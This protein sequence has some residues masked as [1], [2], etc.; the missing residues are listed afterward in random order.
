MKQSKTKQRISR[1]ERQL[2]VLQIQEYIDQ[3][4]PEMKD[5]E[6]AINPCGT[7]ASVRAVKSTDQ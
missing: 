5:S 4:H 6:V 1:T 7:F 3:Y 2:S